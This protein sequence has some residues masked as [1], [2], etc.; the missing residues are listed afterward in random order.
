VQQDHPWPWIGGRLG[1]PWRLGRT[2][3][4]SDLLGGGGGCMWGRIPATLVSS[5]NERPASVEMVKEVG[6]EGEEQDSAGEN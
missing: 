3:V 4:I 5:A 6:E 2:G 1:D